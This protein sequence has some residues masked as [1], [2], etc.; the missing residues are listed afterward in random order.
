LEKTKTTQANEIASLKR[1]VKKL[2]QKKR[3]RTHGLKR[4][5]KV[6][7][8]ARV[9][10]YRDEES[11]GEDASK[12]GRINV[13]N[14]DDDI[15]LVSVQDDNDKEMFDVDALDGEEVFVAGQKENVVEEVVDAAQVNTA[16]II[17]EEITLAQALEVLKTS[18]PKVKGIVFQDPCEST[19][20]K[21]TPAISSQQSQD[22]GK[23]IM[24]EEP[25]KPMKKKDL[26]RLDEEVALKLQAEFDEEERLAREKAKKEKEANIALI[27][28]WDD[29]QAKIEADH[30]LAQRLQ[31]EEQEELSDAEKAT[32][33]QQLLEKRRKH[34]A[35]KRA[36]EQRNKPPT[37]AQQRKIMCTYLKNME[38]KKLK[39]LKNKSFDSIQKMFD[40]A[41]K[42]VN[43]FVDF[44][45]DLVEGSSKRAG[46][47]LIQESSK[48]QKVDDD[49]ETA[50]LK[51][52]MEIIP[53]EEEVTI[54]AIPL[55]VKSPRIVDWKIH[56]EGKKSYYQIIRADGKSQMYMIFSHMLKSFDREDLETLYKLVKAKYKSTRPVED[57][58]L[59]L[60]NDLKTM[61][62]PHVE[63]AV[64]RN[65]QDYKVLSWK[66]YDSCGVHFLRMQH[67]QIYMLV[68]KRYPLTPP[69]ITDMLNKKLQGRIVGIKSLLN[70]ASITAAH[71]RVNYKVNVAEGVNAASE[72]VSTADLLYNG[73]EIVKTNHASAVVHESE[74][75]LEIAEITRKK[76]LN[77][78]KIPL[79]EEGERGFEQTKECYLT[80][81]IP[82]FKM[83][84]EH[85]EG[86]QTAL[87][88][89]VKEMKEIFEQMEA[90]VEQNVVD[91]QCADIERKNLLIENENL[92]AACLSNELLYSVMNAVNTVS[93][94]SE[95]HD[96]YTIEQARC[97]ELEAEIS[98]LK[99]KIQKDD[100][101]RFGNNKSQTSQ[102]TPEF[103]S[104]F[105]INK[106]KEQLQ[107]K[108]NTIRKLKEQISYMNERR[109]HVGALQEQNEIFKA[110]NEKV[111][112]HYK[113]LYDSIK[114]IRVKTIEKTTFLLTE[115]EKLKAQL[116][117]KMKYAAMHTV[118]PNVHAPSMYAIDVEPIS[119]CNRND[120]EVHLDYLKH[121]KESVETLCEIV[122]EAR[123]KKPLDN[124]L[125]NACF[126]TKRSQKLLEYLIGT[127]P[128]EFNKRDKKATTTSL[129]RN[130]QVAFRETCKTSNNNT[131]TH[132]E[133]QK[134]HKTNVPVIPSTGVNSSI[135]DSGSKP[136]SNTKNNKILTA[137]SDNKKKVKDHPRNN[138]SNLK[139]NNRVDSSISSKH[140]VINSNSNFVCKTCNKCIISANHDKCVMKYLK[141]V[142][143]PPLVKNVLSK[144]KQVWKATRK[145]FANVGYQWK[146]TRRK[147]T[148]GEQ[149]PLTRFTK[150]KV[151]PLQQPE[152]VSSTEI[153]ITERF[154]N[155]SQKPLT[156]YTRRNKQ[157]KAISN[158]IY[159]TAET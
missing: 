70:A 10:S 12:K 60:W 35:A 98:K 102:D 43:T 128:K 109:K 11:L 71:I 13:I 21:S 6:G 16:T 125:E 153:V 73:H 30:E 46:E 9:E 72:E 100:H 20:T 136:R 104:F 34:F 61:F 53:D 27:E 96:A 74:D 87:V 150:S 28:E 15:T 24:I 94:F 57:L 3:S 7:A 119:P 95:M 113:E 67:V 79:I 151:V 49:K 124:A 152:H 111:K 122:E 159:T 154:S 44:R 158:G 38:G 123:I 64:W 31:A 134:V 141:F 66:L 105:E 75:T 88:K 17:T 110:E 29:I 148:L 91:K 142:R 5:R 80:E 115:N 108:N 8:T 63:D 50:E 39:D 157:E 99:H 36:E 22:K 101:K 147:F 48:K 155:T 85:F 37:Q 133:Q 103:D 116:K 92:I 112:Q 81:V 68:E 18:K 156:T 62:E 25:V 86:I 56:K 19:T 78:M 138:K 42:R 4:L 106:M 40:R 65:Q 1:R 126:Y 129:S 97:L 55:A 145:L 117:G 139:Q 2:E 114:I 146:P 89:E 84:K 77:K 144:V 82:F 107:G 120:R 83:L 131:Q 58:D 26:I 41:F 130:K 135:E 143:P 140:T 90:E 54:D 93:R 14:A 137:K 149:C 33:F 52:C 32:L 76:M 127:C 118:K 45:T 69:T 23:G 121:L 59:V 132:V 51:Q 47:E